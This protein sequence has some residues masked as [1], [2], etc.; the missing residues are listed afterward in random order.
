MLKPT[1]DRVLVKRDDYLGK[2]KGGIL[3]STKNAEHTGTVVAVGPCWR[4]CC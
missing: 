3:L 4:L 1:S 2:S